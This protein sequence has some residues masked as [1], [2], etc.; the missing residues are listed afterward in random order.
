MTDA[1]SRRAGTADGARGAAATGHPLATA[2]ALG[3]L[4][5]G[6]T[7]ADAAVAAHAVL[8][9]VLPGSCGVGGD[10][11]F[12]VRA[13]DGTVTAHN[14]TGASGAAAPASW[15][16]DGGASVTV[17]GAVAAWWRVLERHGVAPAT[18][19]FAPA[20]RAA[21]DG[22]EVSPALAAQVAEQR[23]RLERGGAGGW[24]L[25]DARPGEV[26]AQPDLALLLQRVATEGPEA[27][28]TGPVADA[29]SRAVRRDGGT[30]SPGDLVV[31][32]TVSTEPVTVGWDGGRVHVQ[33]PVSQGVLLAMALRWLDRHPDL[34]AGTDL[35]HLGAE[36]TE[37]V[38]AYRD[39]CARDGAA[40]LDELLS[41]DPE[42]AARR[43]GPQ[44]YLHT[45][46]VAVADADGTVV[47]SLLTLFDDFGAGTF[48]PEGGFALTNRGGGFTGPPN[49]PG[50]GRKPVHTLAPALVEGP[51]G[52]TAI[53]TPGADGQ[54]QTLLQVLTRVRFAGASLADAVAAPRWRSVASRLHV[55]ASFPDAD[56]LRARGHDVVT[57]D[58]GDGLFGAVVS[59]S[60]TGTSVEAVGDWRRDVAVGGV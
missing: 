18:T 20:V 29:I 39:R 56:G 54:V 41:V 23:G 36:L 48:V 15:A 2:A 19:V 46:G 3:V 22:I 51:S 11:L 28:Y 21:G 34:A 27:F 17:P 26:V 4:A 60:V 30:L 6:G 10:A 53:A 50:P 47:S 35:D 5:G 49:Q 32:D 8:T 33:P 7:A 16:G 55:E 24:P 44:P 1:S 14:G 45:T 37:A 9:V 57:V 52:V 40:L 31:H 25:L 38:F 58:D 42:K 59:A 43:G 12:L 13:P